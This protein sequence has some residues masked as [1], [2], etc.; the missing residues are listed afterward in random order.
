MTPTPIHSAPGSFELVSFNA[1]GAAQPL[2][3]ELGPL[4]LYRQD[5]GF[6]SVL[7]PSL[8]HAAPGNGQANNSTDND[9]ADESVNISATAHS[10]MGP[11]IPCE[12]TRYSGNSVQYKR[13]LR[14]YSC[15]KPGC[16]S[17]TPFS[18]FGGLVR[19]SRA[20]HY[21][22]GRRHDC[23]VSGCKK[24]GENGIKRRD[25]LLAH[26]RNVHPLYQAKKL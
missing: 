6:Y 17:L 19:H 1:T 23:P 3:K 26:I 10:P 24:V 22:D 18:T 15:E 13:P 16:T 20:K 12:F 7:G 21:G 25:N 14:I 5:D 4:P 2:P 11:R 9:F 8:S